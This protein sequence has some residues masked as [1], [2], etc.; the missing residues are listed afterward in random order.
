MSFQ[1]VNPITKD[2]LNIVSDWQAFP[3]GAA[4]NIRQD[5]QCA[6]RR[7]TENIEIRPKTGGSGLDIIVKAGTKGESCYI[8]ACITKNDVDD[9][10][11]NDFYIGEGA[12]VTIVAGCGVHTDGDGESRHN[13]IHRFFME[14]NSKAL[15]L[16]KHYGSGDASVEAARRIIDPETQCE[17]AEGAYLE[18]DT[19]QLEGIAHTHRKTSA[20]LEAGARLVIKENILTEADSKASTDFYVELNGDGC[21][22]DLVS[23]S[24][25]KDDSHQEYHSV[26]VGNAPST[27]HS[28]C[29]AIIV[30]NG[31]VDALPELRAN[32]G[33]AMLIHEAAIGKIAGEQIIKL[34]TLGLTEEE[35]EAR[36]IEGF[37]S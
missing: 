13:G 1:P 34:Q 22:V 6:G 19:S 5:S 11:Y 16:E 12:D 29:D 8:P 7:S 33:D 32:N 2:L 9:L 17:L 35:A 3:E 31:K 20:K 30:G 24:V 10:V 28:E 4:Y 25:A 36:I 18:M 14:K 37:L 23:R 27:G 15:Y 21:G 26:I